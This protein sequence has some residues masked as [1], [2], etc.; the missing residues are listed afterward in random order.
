VAP[1]RLLGWATECIIGIKS[2]VKVDKIWI[3]TTLH[4]RRD[5]RVMGGLEGSESQPAMSAETHILPC[6]ARKSGKTKDEKETD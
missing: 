1:G 3:V 5:T 6:G 4:K 2:N